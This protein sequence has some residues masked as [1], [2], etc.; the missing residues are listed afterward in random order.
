MFNVS[1]PPP[2]SHA[3]YKVMWKKYGTAR[4][5]TDYNLIRR[6][7]FAC[8]VTSAADTTHSEY[9]ILTAFP[10]QQWLRERGYMLCYT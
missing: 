2:V 1:P 9:V 8:W 6:M 7:R 10:Q 3:F 5:A 4:E